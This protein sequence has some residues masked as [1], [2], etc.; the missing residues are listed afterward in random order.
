MVAVSHLMS[1]VVQ[2]L[3]LKFLSLSNIT[4]RFGQLIMKLYLATN[5]TELH[6]RYIRVYI[7]M[8]V[9]VCVCVCVYMTHALLYY[10][11]HLCI[12]W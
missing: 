11:V 9:C 1:L 6:T 12:L 10:T 2:N 5:V 4:L 3:Q 8:C 7:Y